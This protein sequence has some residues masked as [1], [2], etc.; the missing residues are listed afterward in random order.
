MNAIPNCRWRQRLGFGRFQ[1]HSEKFCN[2]PNAVTEA[3]C[4]KCLVCDHEPPPPRVHSLPCVHLGQLQL[5]SQTPT[6][7]AADLSLHTCVL[8]G[9]CSI[10]APDLSA[11]VGVRSCEVCADYLPRDP[12]G[13]D[14]RA[15]LAMAEQY[16]AAIPKYP[17]KHYSGRGVLIA[18]GGD[19]F[20]A[21]LYVTIRALRHVGCTLPI[22][23]WYLG[24]N[25]E[26]S[27]KQQA[28]LK[29]YGVQCIDAD[30]VR[31]QHPARRLDGWEL[32]VFATL[33][34]SFAELLYLD[35]DSYPCRNPEFLFDRAEYKTHGAIFWPDVLKVDDRLKWSAFGV[36]DPRKLGSI[37]SGQYVINKQKCWQ[38]LNLAW[39][40]NDH[41]DYYYKYCHGDKHTFEVAWTRC[42]TPIVMW[43]VQ[44]P[45]VDVAIMQYGP[46][47]LPLFVH[48]CRDKFRLREHRYTT[49]QYT[50]LPSYFSSLP[51]EHECWI[52]LREL[53][54]KLRRPMP[55]RGDVI[56]HSPP[57][58]SKVDRTEYALVTMYTPEIADL[59]AQ[60]G[61]HLAKYAMR[62]GYRMFIGRDTLDGSRHPA[63]SK[64]LLLEQIMLDHPELKWLIWIDSDA[65][66]MQPARRI[67]RMIDERVDFLVAEDRTDT[68]INTG[69][70]MLRN[71]PVSLEML[72][73]AYTK[74]HYLNHPCWEQPAI[75]EAMRELAPR[76]RPRIISRKKFNCF[77]DE[78]EPGDFLIHFAGHS[79][80]LKL[81]RV[82]DILGQVS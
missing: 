12:V 30:E 75:A 69:V 4:A 38:P 73:L 57:P 70:F 48:R 49:P 81:A 39:F 8:H 28:I 18:G 33:H 35:A 5:G 11:P 66:I 53:A 7:I 27:A 20:F 44:A 78:F 82:R 63:W 54:K 22:Q 34:C 21:S 6:S 36:C 74:R 46:D 64:V 14:S 76:L 3:F 50:P 40:Y 19:R 9:S 16:L 10:A 80:E 42:D 15:M 43:Q 25:A 59:G 23:V 61:E 41:S 60:T 37:E 32:K 56:E 65:V 79:H 58:G 24:R 72:R 17:A 68:H 71:C 77:A 26:L 1:C 47:R 62:H 31:K 51:M 13:P 55:S 52:W 45:W 67:D 29:P 2:A